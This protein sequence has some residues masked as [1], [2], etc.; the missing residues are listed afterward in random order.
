MNNY[1][2]WDVERCRAVG[3]ACPYGCAC[4]RADACEAKFSRAFLILEA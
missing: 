2:V 4:I 1:L 3:D